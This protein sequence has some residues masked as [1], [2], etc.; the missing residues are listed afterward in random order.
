MKRF[1]S[2]LLVVLL[3]ATAFPVNALSDQ[4]A[5]EQ[6]DNQ[7]QISENVDGQNVETEDVSEEPAEPEKEEEIISEETTETVVPSTQASEGKTEEKPSRK[8]A[9]AS[10][11]ANNCEFYNAK[12]SPS[13]IKVGGSVTVSGTLRKNTITALGGETVH[14]RIGSADT[15]STEIGNVKTTN[16]I[17][18]KGKFEKAID[19]STIEALKIPGTY[20]IYYCFDGNTSYN[21]TSVKF[22]LTVVGEAQDTTLTISTNNSEIERP[23]GSATLSLSHKCGDDEISDDSITYTFYDKGEVIGNPSSKKTLKIKASDY[24][25]GEHNF[26]AEATADSSGLYNAAETQNTVKVTVSKSKTDEYAFDGVTPENLGTKI[27]NNGESVT[28]KGTFGTPGLIF[29]GLGDQTINVHRGT[30]D[31]TIIA[32]GPTGKTLFKDL[33]DFSVSFDVND[34]NFPDGPDTYPIYIVWEGNASYNPIVL[35]KSLE[36]VAAQEDTTVALTAKEDIVLLPDGK[37]ELQVGHYNSFGFPVEDDA[38]TYSIYEAGNDTAIASGNKKSFEI[39]ASK[40][41]EGEHQ[42]YVTSSETPAYK[43]ATSVENPIPVIVSKSDSVITDISLSQG[44]TNYGGSFTVSGTLEGKDSHSAIENETVYAYLTNA[45]GKLLGSDKTSSKTIISAGGKFSIRIDVTEDIFPAEGNYTLYLSFDGDTSYNETSA[46]KDFEVGKVETTISGTPSSIEMVKT[47]ILAKTI[48]CTYSDEEGNPISYPSGMKINLFEYDE[49]G[50]EV[51]VSSSQQL[52]NKYKIDIYASAL[53]AGEHE[54]YI[55]AEGNNTYKAATSTE[56]VTINVKKS[57]EATFTGIPESLSEVTYEEFVDINGSLKAGSG[58]ASLV[59]LGNE[60]VS[61]YITDTEGTPVDTDTTAAVTGNF[62]TSFEIT[63]DLFPTPGTYKVILCFKG[64]D[65][66]EKVTKE[67]DLVVNAPEIKLTATLGKTELVRP[68]TTTLS[69]SYKEGAKDIEDP[70]VTYS[71]FEVIDGGEVLVAEGLTEKT[72]TIDSANFEIGSHEI[73][74]KASATD[75]YEEAVS[76]PVSFTVSKQETQLNVITPLLSTTEVPYGE[77]ISVTGTLTVKNQAL[78]FI[79]GQ[80]IVVRLETAEG[81]EIAKQDATTAL[82]SFSINVPVTTETFPVDND[83]Y[84]ICICY[85]GTDVYDAAETVSK[86]IKITRDDTLLVVTNPSSSSVEHP[87][88]SELQIS[89][90][91]S[92]IDIARLGGINDVDVNVRIDDPDGDIAASATTQKGLLVSGEY[93]I[94]LP[95]TKENFPDRTKSYTLYISFDGNESYKKSNV[96]EKTF[97][98][99]KA[100][101]TVSCE[102]SDLLIA[103]PDGE[104]TLTISYK[105]GD[106]EIEADDITYTVYAT[107][108]GTSIFEKTEIASSTSKEIKIPAKALP[109]GIYN[110]TVKASGNEDYKEAESKVLD[111]SILTITKTESQINALPL[112]ISDKEMGDSIVLAGYLT[113]KK[114]LEIIPKG[115]N[116]ETIHVRVGSPKG[117]E[118]ATATTKKALLI[119]NGQFSFNIPVNEENF[120]DGYG[121]YTLYFCFDGNDDYY[122]SNMTRDVNI[123]KKKATVIAE[124]DLLDHVIYRPDGKADLT[125][126]YLDGLKEITDEDVTFTVYKVKG[127][128]EEKLYEGKDKRIEIDSKDFIPGSY[129]LKVKASETDKYQEAESKDITLLIVGSSNAYINDVPYSLPQTDFGKTFTIE[130][131]LEDGIILGKGINDKEVNVVLETI[132]GKVIGVDTTYTL[133]DQDGHFSIPI[134]AT[135]DIFTEGSKEYTLHI[136]F[137]GD[138]DYNPA[139]V[140]RNIFIG[141]RETTLDAT[142]GIGS[143]VIY[144]PDET[145]RI[146]ASYKS[147][148]KEITDSDITYSLYELLNGGVKPVVLDSSSKVFNISAEDFEEGVHTFYVTASGNDKYEPATSGEVKIEIRK[149]KTEINGIPSTYG[150]KDFGEK[151]TISGYLTD[152]SLI[153]SGINGKEIQVIIGDEEGK[154][155]AITNTKATLLTNGYFTAEVPVDTDIFNEGPGKYDIT[156]SFQGDDDYVGA[157]AKSS[158]TVDKIDTVITSIISDHSIYRPGDNTK[159]T[160]SYRNGFKEIKDTDIEYSVYEI[161]NGGEKL[162]YKG[163]DKTYTLNAKDFTPGIHYIRVKASGNDMYKEATSKDLTVFT[164]SKASTKLD[165]LA[166]STDDVRLGKKDGIVAGVILSDATHGKRIKGQKVN[167]Y[168]YDPDGE[169]NPVYFGSGITDSKGFAKAYLDTSKIE[170]AGE[171]KV[172][173]T[174]A[175]NKDYKGTMTLVNPVFTVHE[176][177]VEEITVVTDLIYGNPE[178]ENA[179][180]DVVFDD[181]IAR[182]DRV[183]YSIKGDDTDI[184]KSVKAKGNEISIFEDI[185]A[186]DAGDYTITVYA[187]DISNGRPEFYSNT[188]DFTIEPSETNITVSV[189]NDNPVYG[190]D[191]NVYSATL[192]DQFGNPV[193]DETVT[194]TFTSKNEGGKIYEFTGKTD[195]NGVFSVIVEPVDFV[196]GEYEVFAEYK[197]EDSINYLPSGKSDPVDLTVAKQDVTVKVEVNPD[198][199]K[200]N[201]QEVEFTAT[202][203]GENGEK[204]VTPDGQDEGR[205]VFYANGEEIGEVEVKDGVAKLLIDPIDLKPG[206]FDITA[207]YLGNAY[208]NEDESEA[209]PLEVKKLK[210]IISVEVIDDGDF[211]IFKVTAKDEAGNPITN[212]TFNIG[213]QRQLIG[214]ATTDKNGVGTLRVSKK[215]TGTGAKALSVAFAGNDYLDEAEYFDDIVIKEVKKSTKNDSKTKQN[216][217]PVNTGSESNA[218][219]VLV[220]L[221]ILVALVLVIYNKKRSARHFK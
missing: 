11:G 92:D 122:A 19:T 173:A 137:D 20:D 63:K 120:P 152:N 104:T 43:G 57:D 80:K 26:T 135:E 140:T 188:L 13:T 6:V 85:D 190:V 207:K 52:L 111:L 90:T 204:I 176:P 70:D 129:N 107:G 100:N 167:F 209:T 29:T 220:A 59:P 97:T 148:N 201:M 15:T 115:I 48:T 200:Y 64:N 41:G 21:P 17:G 27:I 2:I 55:R 183:W 84:T 62:E 150:N 105:A 219:Y 171:Y 94:N 82:G 215:V 138:Y 161:L 108:T 60:E 193:K 79:S 208:F 16:T 12:L 14:F 158:V 182:A 213:I 172:F 139:S 22:S 175:G 74:V 4:G 87:Y 46:T 194:I 196:P 145:G 3:L 56:P 51:P 49:E 131:N 154:V 141:K 197:A 5:Q 125:I 119:T 25:L 214:K 50:N 153:P 179:Q 8:N 191:N 44:K 134:E 89:G 121:F 198:S 181:F 157:I 58:L 184:T 30:V 53:S 93:T 103:R 206:T 186:L 177:K 130:G 189:E 142:L 117:R 91:L 211:V 202:I 155:V 118:I 160:I 23:D 147:N 102:L 88:G 112:T 217:H 33:G 9:P 71:I 36:V 164:V 178:L 98:I 86:T 116:D 210:T 76:E 47:D 156:I 72:Y 185:S 203:L 216:K 146:I 123:V 18:S 143:S 205:V 133:D 166:L 174:Y 69:I 162:L 28:I 99:G 34:T 78:G 65:S 42:L 170:D 110:I 168:Y 195:E 114:L 124:L 218:V 54:I 163:N 40:L 151:I 66:Y 113:D 221:L 39:S 199:A 77:S 61:V 45:E 159:L 149:T 180:F 75:T 67:Y 127:E 126:H 106:N 212:E 192:L 38:I 144:R 136:T 132:D 7:P 24:A 35:E 10:T 187:C 128:E 95:V 165:Y 81:E 32:S 83:T 96:V 109:A 73:I 31:G 169:F 37:V 101:T 1:L 68:A